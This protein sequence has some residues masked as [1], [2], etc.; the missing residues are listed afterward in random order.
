MPSFGSRKS[1][2]DAPG[3]HKTEAI[4]GDKEPRKRNQPGRHNT[5]AEE[6]KPSVQ[7]GGGGHKGGGGDQKVH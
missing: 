5:T 1:D 4:H 3:A 6:V 2:V 7:G